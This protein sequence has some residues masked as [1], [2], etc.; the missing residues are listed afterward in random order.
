LLLYLEF[1]QAG[2]SPGTAEV[3]DRRPGEGRFE[4][5]RM[6]G[7]G[8]AAMNKLPHQCTSAEKHASPPSIILRID[9]IFFLP[10]DNAQCMPPPD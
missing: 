9:P 1:H 2:V 8:K 6:E 7:E 3:A 4:L 10:K 5:A